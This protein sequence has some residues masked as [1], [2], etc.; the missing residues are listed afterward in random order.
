MSISASYR[1]LHIYERKERDNP[2]GL[3]IT[4]TDFLVY[5]RDK[6][7]S[8][9]MHRRKDGRWKIILVARLIPIHISWGVLEIL[10]EE[11]ASYSSILAW[12]IAWTEETD[13]QQSMG[14]Q[15]VRRD[16]VTK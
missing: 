11:M 1:V 16:L 3:S 7:F 10:E 9:Y 15:R 14:S 6:Y 4:A 13:R 12:E 5:D 8:R 2:F